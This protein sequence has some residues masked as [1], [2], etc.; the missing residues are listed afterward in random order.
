MKLPRTHDCHSLLSRKPIS[1]P[2]VHL[3]RAPLANFETNERRR[4]LSLSLSLSHTHTHTPSL[5]SRRVT[6][7]LSVKTN[8]AYYEVV[9]IE[10]GC[11]GLERVLWEG[12]SAGVDELM[13]LELLVFLGFV[14]FLLSSFFCFFFFFFVFFFFFFF[15]LVFIWLCCVGEYSSQK[16]AKK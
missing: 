13:T 10:S 11:A 3:P 7:I 14:F 5:C 9:L 4:S 8:Y 1:H 2:V 15:F 6:V 16:I 12:G